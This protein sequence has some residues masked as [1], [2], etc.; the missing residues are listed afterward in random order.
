MTSLI[1]HQVTQP[2]NSSFCSFGIFCVD[3]FVHNVIVVIEAVQRNDHFPSIF[4]DG[5]YVRVPLQVSAQGTR[6]P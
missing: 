4:T 2:Y 5:S 1:G 3:P 6:P